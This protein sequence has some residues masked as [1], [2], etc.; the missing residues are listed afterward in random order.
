[1]FWFLC[2]LRCC[3]FGAPQVTPISLFPLWCSRPLALDW[4]CAVSR[5]LTTHNPS[6]CRSW[7]F[8]LRSRLVLVRPLLAFMFS[9]RESWRIGGGVRFGT[10]LLSCGCVSFPS[11][12]SCSNVVSLC[13][14]FAKH[15]ISLSISA[16]LR[17]PFL[18]EPKWGWAF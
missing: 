15:I 1:M 6:Q 5:G 3:K 16:S 11:A 9:C 4:H 14:P 13:L 12:C 2:V 17:D 7:V 18:L 10:R 8:C